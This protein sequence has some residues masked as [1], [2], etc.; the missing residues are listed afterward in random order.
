MTKA[1]YKLFTVLLFERQGGRCYSEP[2]LFMTWPIMQ[3]LVSQPLPTLT[4]GYSE[5]SGRLLFLSYT[6]WAHSLGEGGPGGGVI[7][8]TSALKQLVSTFH[9]HVSTC[10]YV[11]CM[12][13]VYV[14]MNFCQVYL[15]QN[16]L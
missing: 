4:T 6:L 12:C 13:T 3:K 1:P 2:R 14:I 11:S 7:E 10:M 8:F 9:T 5:R 15:L 16:D